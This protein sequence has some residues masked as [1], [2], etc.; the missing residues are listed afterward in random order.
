MPKEFVSLICT[1]NESEDISVIKISSLSISAVKHFKEK[2]SINSNSLGIEITSSER[3]RR[4][5][6]KPTISKD[7]EKSIK[8]CLPTTKCEEYIAEIEKLFEGDPEIEIINATGEN[9]FSLRM[10]NLKNTSGPFI[11]LF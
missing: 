8:F 7:G 5:I 6:F 2:M 1:K 9:N 3:K 4:K 10:Y 11:S